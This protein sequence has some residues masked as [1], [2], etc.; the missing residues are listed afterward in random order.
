MMV[1]VSLH[2]T[3]KGMAEDEKADMLFA[4]DEWKKAVKKNLYK[5]AVSLF[6][7]ALA[8]AESAIS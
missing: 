2:R 7:D 5:K 6:K 8:K 3:G 4:N 1:D